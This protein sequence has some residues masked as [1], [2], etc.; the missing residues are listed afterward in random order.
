VTSQLLFLLSFAVLA[1][2]GAVLSPGGDRARPTANADRSASRFRVW[3]RRRRTGGGS[4]P[5]ASRGSARPAGRDPVA[6][7]RGGP[8]AT[9]SRDPGRERRP[10]SRLSR[11]FRWPFQRGSSARRVEARTADAPG[12]GGQTA[13]LLWPSRAGSHGVV[14][15]ARIDWPRRLL[16]L[17]TVAAAGVLVVGVVVPRLGV[18]LGLGIAGWLTARQ[19]AARRQRAE[20][21]ARLA[22]AAPAVVDLLGACLL[23]VL[24]G[25]LAV[26]KVAE[27]APPALAPD[28]H[29]AAVDLGWAAPRRPPSGAR[30]NGPGSTSYAPP[31]VR[32]KP[33]N[34]GVHPRPRRSGRGRRPSAP[35]SAS[36]PKPPP[37]APRS[38]SRSRS[39]SAS[40]QRSS[41]SPSSH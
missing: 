14:Q 29:L 37:G 15:P 20:E 16:I 19:A 17:V 36:K 21:H 33:P 1:M 26:L 40:C 6:G 4:G 12:G 41:C 9:R 5:A 27:R 30:P 7:D 24:N 8:G 10:G 22:A 31:P 18:L 2:A 34:A 32:S 38:A 23:A 25:H 35:G 39:S 3:I 13:G 28:L 11:R